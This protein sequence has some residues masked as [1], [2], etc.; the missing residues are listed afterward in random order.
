M[1]MPGLKSG[2]R[3]RD[4]QPVKDNSYMAKAT[5]KTAPRCFECKKLIKGEAHT[6]NSN[7]KFGILTCDHCFTYYPQQC[8]VCFNFTS[9]EEGAIR[10]FAPN[11]GEYGDSVICPDCKDQ[12]VEVDDFDDTTDQWGK[13]NAAPA[14]QRKTAPPI[15]TYELG[16]DGNLKQLMC[17]VCQRP[18]I[19]GKCSGG[20]I[21][22]KL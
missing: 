2:Q 17:G 6:V 12:P 4:G 16:T 7:G 18:W 14:A 5:K 21:N 8:D 13:P 22:H 3:G 15:P 9:Y 11:A 20:F 19:G 10:N 1:H